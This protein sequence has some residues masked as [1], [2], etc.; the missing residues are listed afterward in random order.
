[1][2]KTFSYLHLTDIHFDG[3]DSTEINTYVRRFLEY[4]S[5]IGTEKNSP[6]EFIVLTGDITFSGRPEQ[7][8]FFEDIFLSRLF[9]TIEREIPVFVVP[10]NHDQDRNLLSAI[11]PNILSGTTTCSDADDFFDHT[12]SQ[13]VLNAPFQSFYQYTEG[14]KY[15]IR[16][17]GLSWADTFDTRDGLKIGISG[18]NDAWASGFAEMS[19]D[20]SDRKLLIS[21]S[22][23]QSAIPSQTDLDLKLLLVHHPLSWYTPQVANE[24]K[25]TLF[26]KFDLVHFGHVHTIYDL[27]QHILPNSKYSSA[28]GFAFHIADR[29]TGHDHPRG[30]SIIEV[31]VT[32]TGKQAELLYHKYSPSFSDTG[33]ARFRDL[34]DQKLG[35]IFISL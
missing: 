8:V 6:L 16:G 35:G 7:F 21:G 4:L 19:K 34:D 24:V 26:S 1:M 31:D 18:L 30:F 11:N 22:Q 25:R 3:T 10:G 29:S 5:S 14:T 13:F 12:A 9:H 28:P 2:Q 15:D 32:D 20:T 23:I 33:F 27:E 17:S